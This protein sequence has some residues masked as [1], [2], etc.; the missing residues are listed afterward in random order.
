MSHVIRDR[1]AKAKAVQ[2][3]RFA[4]RGIYSNAEME[5]RD[6]KM[7]CPIDDKGEELLKMAVDRLGFSVRAYTR[8]LKV[9]RTIADL[10]GEACIL[11]SHISEAI[12]Y[13]QM[14]KYF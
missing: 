10:N 1:V 9:A 5:T 4:G 6:V 14:D 12:Q 13:R 8:V 3:E 7:F 11:P 2:L